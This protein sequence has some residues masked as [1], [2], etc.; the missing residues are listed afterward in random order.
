MRGGVVW[1]G[2]LQE[3]GGVGG[4]QQPDRGHLPHSA[5]AANHLLPP[6]PPLAD[7]RLC[8]PGTE[9]HTRHKSCYIRGFQSGVC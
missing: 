1:V 6:T 7:Q 4:S 3:T 2:V 8:Q 9:T 5:A